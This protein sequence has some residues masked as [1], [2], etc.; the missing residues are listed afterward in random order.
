MISMQERA[1]LAGG[2]LAVKS[3]LGQGTTV[4]AM[5]PLNHHANKRLLIADDH[6]LML[7][8][9]TRLLAGEFTIVGTAANGRCSRKRNVSIPT[10]CC[11]T[12]A[13]R[14]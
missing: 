12:S 8:G 13:C 11:S 6:A 4:M 7:D 5:I 14:S 9:L 1:R 10:S 2:T 3:F